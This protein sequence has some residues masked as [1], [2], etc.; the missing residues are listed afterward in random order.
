MIIEEKD[1]LL[2]LNP[3]GSRFDLSLLYVVNAKNPEKR[4]EEFKLVGYGMHLESCFR[5]IINHRIASRHEVLS[6]K[7]YIE[8]Y[9]KE[10]DELTNLI[11]VSFDENE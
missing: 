1:F 9:K 6:L 5:T 10:K 8:E 2:E 4:R 3:N 11:K 7:K